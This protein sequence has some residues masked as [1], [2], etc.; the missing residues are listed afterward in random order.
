[1]PQPFNNAVMTDGG[2]RLLTMAQAGEI[3]IQ[4]TRM[5][6]GNG[7]YSEE[8]RRCPLCSL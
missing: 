5:A 8:E 3:R 1:M 2:A 7:V 6:I 4:F